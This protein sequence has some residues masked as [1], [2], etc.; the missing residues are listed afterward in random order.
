MNGY[1]IG[2]VLLID[3][4]WVGY[5]A[6]VVFS[7]QFGGGPRRNVGSGVAIGQRHREAIGC[8]VRRVH[9]GRV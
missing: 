1:L 3:G 4:S 6:M 7:V 9:D 8:P 5:G 2:L